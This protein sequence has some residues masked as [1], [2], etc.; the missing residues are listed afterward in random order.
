MDFDSSEESPKEEER[1]SGSD[2]E[3]ESEEDNKPHEKIKLKDGATII[4]Y[5]VEV[6]EDEPEEEVVYAG[7][8]KGIRA[9]KRQ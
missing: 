9:L 1:K 4:N 3:D 2:D 7:G 5:E 8:I 6:E